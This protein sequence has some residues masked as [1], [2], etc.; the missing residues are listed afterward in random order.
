MLG[1]GASKA[2]QQNLQRTKSEARNAS[3]E[4]MGGVSRPHETLAVEGKRSE[5]T[6]IE[7]S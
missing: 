6:P 4:T 7:P 1:E 2:Q 5:T 3:L